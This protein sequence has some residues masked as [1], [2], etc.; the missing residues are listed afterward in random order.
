[1]YRINGF[2]PPNPYRLG[3][4]GYTIL[5]DREFA[6]KALNT[7]QPEYIKNFHEDID[8]LLEILK[9][10]N[11]PYGHVRFCNDTMLIS[12]ISVFGNSCGLDIDWKSLELVIDEHNHGYENDLAYYPHNV[13]SITQAYSLLSVFFVWYEYTEAVMWG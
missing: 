1:M 8:N 4:Y 3:G 11:K 6:L 2:S 13:D 10:S 9:I 5:L 7:K 12:N